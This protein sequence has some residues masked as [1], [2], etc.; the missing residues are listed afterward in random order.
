M[1]LF[2]LPNL[3]LWADLDD[4]TFQP[5]RTE[6]LMDNKWINNIL[7]QETESPSLINQ[8][9]CLCAGN[10]IFI[11]PSLTVPWGVISW[12]TSKNFTFT[13]T[14]PL[15]LSITSN[16]YVKPQRSAV[17]WNAVSP[18]KTNWQTG[19]SAPAFLQ[20]PSHPQSKASHQEATGTIF[21]SVSDI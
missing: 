20:S 13:A 21:P 5:I 7:V 16:W 10:A 11:T 12:P 14:A 9:L 18:K 1:L 4:L 19:K 8:S 6:G 2:F 17:N 15:L 3:G